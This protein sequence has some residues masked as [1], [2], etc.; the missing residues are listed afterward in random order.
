MAHSDKTTTLGLPDNDAAEHRMRRALG[1]ELTAS[2]RTPRQSRARNQGR[3]RFIDDG[4]VPV[5]MLTGRHRPEAPDAVREQMAVLQSALDSER[6]QRLAAE[7]ALAEAQATV[8]NLQT[9]LAHAEMA[10]AEAL[11]TERRVRLLAEATLQGQVTASAAQRQNRAADPAQS[12]A[13]R[14]IPGR[15]AKPSTAAEPEPVK[16]WLPSYQ[17][18]MRKQRR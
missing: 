8:Q 17:A 18:K 5:V 1:L 14:R 9:K 11:A 10:S 12:A 7:R 2:S 3:T 13:G 4:E 15:R 6:M 16:W